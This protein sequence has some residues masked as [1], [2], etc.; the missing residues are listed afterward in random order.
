MGFGRKMVGIEKKI[1]NFLFI[2]TIFSPNPIKI[3]VT[4]LTTI[5]KHIQ[6]AA[7]A[8]RQ[9]RQQPATTTPTTTS[10]LKSNQSSSSTSL[11]ITTVRAGHPIIIAHIFIKGAWGH[12]RYASRSITKTLP[13]CRTSGGGAHRYFSHCLRV[14]CHMSL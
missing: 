4:K 3:K 9:A 11:T 8:H 6:S 1:A 12:R 2:F 7:R 14:D 10:S 13:E 5:Q